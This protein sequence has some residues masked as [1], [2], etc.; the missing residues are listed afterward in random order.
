VPL[1]SQTNTYNTF[2]NGL[3]AGNGN[4]TNQNDILVIN[5]G[6]IPSI[7]GTSYDQ[8]SNKWWFGK[9]GTGSGG[10][11]FGTFTTNLLVANGTNNGA[12]ITATSNTTAAISATAT[13]V[14]ALT[15]SYSVTGSTTTP[16]LNLSGTWNNS[17]LVGTGI[18]LNI[19]DTA[20]NAN[21]LLIDL[22]TNSA[23]VFKIDKLGIATS[24]G[25]KTTGSLSFGSVSDL[26]L[27]RDAANTLAQRNGTNA[28]TFNIYSTYTSG[29]V[30]AR[31][32]I[33][34]AASRSQIISEST[35][36][37][38]VPLEFSSYSSSS[39]P[40]TSSITSGAC[41]VWKNTGTG[42]V[43]LWINDGGTMKS[44]ALI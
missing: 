40:T 33:A 23:S 34:A 22:Q 28:Q 35:G 32:R 10:Y 13:N 15:A 38:V 8:T 41:G 44:V 12:A 29:T 36:G 27:V 2:T 11:V 18:K 37:T 42:V 31:L 9:D 14:P 21:S 39:D 19:T 26:V 20:S 1:L 25:L 16:L 3:I 7:Q 6:S 30:F 17:G 43:K 24:A 5:G 4:S